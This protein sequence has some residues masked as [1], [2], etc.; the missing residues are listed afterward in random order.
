MDY[1]E[2]LDFNKSYDQGDV[3]EYEYK[4]F[5]PSFAPAGTY[6]LAYTFKTPEGKD[7]GCWSFSFK[8]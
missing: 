7:N 6:V 5:I 1:S 4:T 2:T 8:L 3:I